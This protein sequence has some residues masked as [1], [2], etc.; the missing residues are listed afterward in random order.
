MPFIVTFPIHAFHHVLGQCVNMESSSLF[1]I[2]CN[3]SHLGIMTSTQRKM[4]MES[5]FFLVQR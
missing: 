2:L 1:F 5:L 3:N 4:H